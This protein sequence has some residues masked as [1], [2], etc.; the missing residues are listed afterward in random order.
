MR[1]FVTGGS[2]FLGRNLIPYLVEHGWEV[3]AL[4]RSPDAGAAV[5]ASGAEPA[6]GDITSGEGLVEHLRG[7][8][9]AFHAA[10]WANDWGDPA[11][12]WNA[13]VVGTERMLTAAREAGVKRFVHVSTEAV[14]VGAPIVRATEEWP[15]P[16][17]SLGLYTW[18][19][20]EAE[21]LARAA[22]APGFDVMVV[23]PRFIWGKGDTSLM[24]KF[25]EAAKSG[26][27][28]WF[29]GGRYLTST[30]HVR[31]SCEGMLKAA[32]KGAPGEIYFLT[33]GEP[34]AF[35]EIIS[36]LLKKEGVDPDVGSIPTFVAHAS[37]IVMDATWRLLHLKSRPPLPH[38]SFHLKGEDV[39]VVDAKARKEIGY[40][41]EM[42]IEAGLA[43]IPDRAVQ[44]R[45]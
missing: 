17:R 44:T 27:L 1:A 15:Y 45:N 11:V 40:T 12:A 37:S 26:T 7:C 30:C 18:T 25:V 2:G 10:A 32:E 41:G 21:K 36:A 35:R 3:R 14:L 19:K 31:N 5:R 16:T 20:R 4:A 13:N 42:T 28:K 29:G 8:D 43:E 38:A 34:I 23:R 6:S 39:T 22:S 9:A 24:P 33:D